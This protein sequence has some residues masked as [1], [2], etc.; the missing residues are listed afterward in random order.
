MNRSRT[1]ATA[2]IITVATAASA[3]ASPARADTAPGH[4]AVHVARVAEVP[5]TPPPPI[6]LGRGM[7]TMSGFTTEEREEP[8]ASLLSS[9]A[10]LLGTT[11]AASA[12]VAAT[13]QRE[14]DHKLYVPV[15]GPWMDLMKRERCAGRTACAS[16]TANRVLLVADGVLQGIGALQVLGAFAFPRKFT[17]VVPRAGHVHVTPT[18]MAGGAGITAYGAF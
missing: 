16:E 5:R 14:A 7:R 17:E 12:I 18:A 1:R 4:S 13:S 10:F 11:Y 15:A 2:L 6:A 8:D 9:G 3:W